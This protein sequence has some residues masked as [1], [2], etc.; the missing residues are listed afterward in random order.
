MSQPWLPERE[1]KEVS[2]VNL[3][4]KRIQRLAKVFLDPIATYEY[5]GD[6]AEAFETLK[7]A[8]ITAAKELAELKNSDDT[9]EQLKAWEK[10]L[11]KAQEEFM[12]KCPFVY[13]EGGVGSTEKLTPGAKSDMQ[14]FMYWQIQKCLL[15]TWEYYR[16]D[17]YD[18]G[19]EARARQGQAQS[20]E[21][22]LRVIGERLGLEI[23]RLNQLRKDVSDLNKY[24]RRQS[25]D[26]PRKNNLLEEFQRIYELFPDL[27]NSAYVGFDMENRLSKD[28]EEKL[29]NVRAFLTRFHIPDYPEL[30]EIETKVTAIRDALRE[31]LKDNKSTVTKYSEALKKTSEESNAEDNPPTE[32][33]PAPEETK[34]DNKP[35][36]MDRIRNWRPFGRGENI[37][38]LLLE[39]KALGDDSLYKS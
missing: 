15:Q 27:N 8:C 37:K 13:L 17:P 22:K 12:T 33:S 1:Q 30:H 10:R 25:E 11:S 16:T 20:E 21:K 38:S 36:L 24:V 31:L 18:I 6:G 2:I 29:E 32:H 9:L 7:T 35:T 19:A 5:N 34:G 4:L 3:R 14:K 39:L 23:N 28:I 26:M